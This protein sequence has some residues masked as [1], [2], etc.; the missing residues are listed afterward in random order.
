MRA[1]RGRWRPAVGSSAEARGERNPRAG[2]AAE[3]GSA[4]ASRGAPDSDSGSA[5]GAPRASRLCPLEPSLPP[6]SFS[7]APAKPEPDSPGL[8]SLY[9]FG[10]CD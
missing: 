3:S 1:Q 10:P 2:A 4:P 9:D 7:A 5:A 6:A 8:D